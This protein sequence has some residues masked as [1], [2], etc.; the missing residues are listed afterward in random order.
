MPEVGVRELKNRLSYYLARVKEG[1]R[2]TVT[3]RGREIAVILPV[4]QTGIEAELMQLVKEGLASW[5]GGKPRGASRRIESRGRPA[6][7][8][9]P[10]DRR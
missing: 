1:E 6:S 9:V 2:V 5:R 7:A 3:D 8:L 4:P 10:E